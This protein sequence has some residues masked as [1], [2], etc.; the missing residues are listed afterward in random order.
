[1]LGTIGM[2]FWIRYNQEQPIGIG[3]FIISE[4]K[5]LQGRLIWQ[6]VNATSAG[7]ML[8]RKTANIIV[9]FTIAV[10]L[11]LILHMNEINEII[12]KFLPR[13]PETLVHHKP[14][15]KS[16]RP[17]PPEEKP[18]YKYFDDYADVIYKVWFSKDRNE[19][20]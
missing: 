4:G 16:E 11:F 8:S 5:V 14:E 12:L 7:N 19:N 15:I 6:C 18:D 17:R 1:M 9:G 13:P 2:P 20:T 3:V 10:M